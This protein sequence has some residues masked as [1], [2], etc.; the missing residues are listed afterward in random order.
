MNPWQMAQQMKH[1]LQQV[2]WRSGSQDLVFGRRGSV[3]VYA[4]YPTQEQ[5]PTGFPWV[6]V[7]IDSA[8]F[9]AEDP[10]L[11]V[12]RFTL[13]VAA[14]VMG[15]RLGESG[16][17]GGAI[18]DYGRSANRGVGEVAERARAAVAGI[19]GADGAQIL[20]SGAS[21][22]S[23]QV[24]DPGRHVVFH[25]V[26]LEAVCTSEPYY[27]AP[28][29]LRWAGGQWL[30]DGGHCEARFDF[31][32]YRLLRKQGE[33]PSGDVSDGILVYEGT[34]PFAT[35]P[36]QSGW[37]YTAIAQYSSRQGAGIEGAS[38]PEVGAYLAP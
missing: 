33:E 13:L 28:Q 34:D 27:A 25:E 20:V 14:E 1:L 12:Q 21:S 22:G 7:G 6:L 38:G 16:L 11:L 23:P 3:A 29:C 4:G 10:G 18:R 17:I 8:T 2:R 5:I 15:D 37:I 19:T 35:A 32:N 24:L 26:N 30:W 31:R 36:Q 9:D